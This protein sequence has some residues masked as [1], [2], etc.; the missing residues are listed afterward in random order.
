MT[1]IAREGWVGTHGYAQFHA[2]CLI[3][4]VLTQKSRVLRRVLTRECPAPTKSVGS[5]GATARALNP[6]S[7]ALRDR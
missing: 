2:W 4:R 7:V 5:L 3:L 1:A 6:S